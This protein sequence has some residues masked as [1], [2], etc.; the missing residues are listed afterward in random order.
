MTLT[1]NICGEELEALVHTD[2]ELHPDDAADGLFL[3]KFNGG[4]PQDF[5][6]IDDDESH[7]TWGEYDGKPW[8]VPSTDTPSDMT[9]AM[10]GEI[11][12]QDDTVTPL[13]LE[14]QR[15]YKFCM[16]YLMQ[17]GDLAVPGGR[18][19]RDTRDCASI[20]IIMSI[21][22]R[23]H[24]GEPISYY[25]LHS[26]MGLVVNSDDSVTEVLSE[27]QYILDDLGDGIDVKELLGDEYSPQTPL[28]RIAKWADVET[29]D[30]TLT[31]TL[32]EDDAEKLIAAIRDREVPF[33][34]HD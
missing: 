22:M 21:V 18:Y 32:D 33:D 5:L 15:F 23:Y 26:D 20:A 12:G 8:V 17:D 31:I 24:S 14:E 34:T 28:E 13:K 7:W 29:D 19:G 16:A 4:I 30:D 6:D 10:M 25:A 3:H 27:S 9:D 1:C 2:T 11:P